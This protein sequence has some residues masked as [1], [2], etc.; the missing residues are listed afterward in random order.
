[1]NKDKQKAAEDDPLKIG[2]TLGFYH[3]SIQASWFLFISSILLQQTKL[4]MAHSRHFFFKEK[5]MDEP[6]LFFHLFLSFQTH[7]TIFTSNK[8]EK[9][10][11]SIWC[12]DSNSRPLDHES[13]P[14]TTR[15]GLPLKSRHLFVAFLSPQVL[16]TYKP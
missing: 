3:R 5:K 7:I 16:M 13:P 14:I 15:P 12:R 9:S 4:K 2:E 1:M 10:S 11:S 8:C 6:G